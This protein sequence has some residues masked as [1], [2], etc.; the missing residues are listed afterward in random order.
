MKELKPNITTYLEDYDITVNAYLTYAQIQQI[1]NA[2][3]K[4]D[5]WAERAENRDMLMLLH[6]TDIGKENLEKYS[7][8]DLLTSGLVDAVS[9]EI[10]NLYE[11]DNAVQ[12]QESLNVALK[13]LSA[14]LPSM[15]KPLEEVIQKHGIS[16]R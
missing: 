12:Y 16:N 15:L 14:E 2:M 9:Y 3:M 8:D 7:Y 6:A 4:F 11:I 13:K 1:A 5:T 10:V